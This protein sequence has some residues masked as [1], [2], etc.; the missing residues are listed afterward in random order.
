MPGD[1]TFTLAE[2]SLLL[3]PLSEDQLRELVHALRWRHHG[4][5]RTGMPGRPAPLYPAADLFRL[6]QAIL[7]LI[8]DAE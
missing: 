7:P 6:H 3:P 8:G 5:K 1:V 4:T 2:A